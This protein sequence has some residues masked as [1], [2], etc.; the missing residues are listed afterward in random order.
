MRNSG[1]RGAEMQAVCFSETSVSTCSP[2][3][4][5]TQK[6]NIDIISAVRNSSR[7]E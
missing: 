4:V 5:T 3:G 7:L 2:H 6:T 1:S